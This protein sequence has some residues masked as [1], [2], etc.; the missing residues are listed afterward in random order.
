MSTGSVNC[1]NAVP[2]IVVSSG[3]MR[4]GQYKRYVIALW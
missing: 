4:Y 1:R 3:K 2:C